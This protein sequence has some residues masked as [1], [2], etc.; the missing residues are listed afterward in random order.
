MP[1]AVDQEFINLQFMIDLAECSISEVF[2]E[3]ITGRESVGIVKGE[4]DR[5]FVLFLF[6]F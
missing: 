3:V 6:F 1:L 5:G 4:V 2:S